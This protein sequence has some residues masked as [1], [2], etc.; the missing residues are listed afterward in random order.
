MTRVELSGSQFDLANKF[1]NP[2]R[3]AQLFIINHGKMIPVKEFGV[4]NERGSFRYLED[5]FNRISLYPG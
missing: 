4:L 1:N 5:D 3:P 2:P